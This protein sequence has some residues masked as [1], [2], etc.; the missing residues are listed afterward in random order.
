VI[1]SCGQPP[2][3]SN[4]G[5]GVKVHRVTRQ[6]GNT[7]YSGRIVC[8]DAVDFLGTLGNSTAAVVLVDPPFNLGKVYSAEA[9][10]IDK[11]K[12]K[13]YESWLL[14]VLLEC[15]RVLMPGGA[16]YLYHIPVWAMRIGAHLELSGLTFQHWIAVSMK[17]GFV[18][19][20]RLYPAHYALLMF[21]KGEPKYF[22]RPK[23]EPQKCRHCGGYVKSYGSRL[24]IIKAKGINLSDFWEDIS[25]VRH[26][27]TK[28]REANEL[29]SRIFQRVIEISG[30][31]GK[32]YVDPFVGSGSGVLAASMAGMKFAACDIVQENCDLVVSRL[33]QYR[34]DCL[35]GAHGG[36]S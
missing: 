36:K 10:A 1:D 6:F 22:N 17:N 3:D 20:Q 7:Y 19:G 30:H 34:K 9:P 11:R 21:T 18:R 31:S 15:K 28:H 2:H 4:I 12:P 24:P 25:P 23:L 33:Q 26:K 13:D 27:H 35:K 32:L 8:G 29:P 5:T 14:K 16:L